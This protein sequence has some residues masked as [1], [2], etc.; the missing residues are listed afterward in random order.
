MKRAY[1]GTEKHA[2]QAAYLTAIS[3]WFAGTKETPWAELRGGLVLGGEELWQKVRGL[4]EGKQGMDEARWTTRQ[5]AEGLRERVRELVAGEADDQVKIWARVKLGGER[6]VEVAK[7]YGYRHQ[8]GV[9]QVMRRLE[10][11]AKDDGD[12]RCKL[13]HLK[14]QV[15]SVDSAE[16]N[17]P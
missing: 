9:G 3:R 4:V 6:P 1:W 15:C 14:A 13:E 16:K 2:A 12:L 8:S 7:E 10:D 17:S 5:A 11:Y